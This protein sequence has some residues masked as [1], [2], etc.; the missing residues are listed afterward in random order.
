MLI[1]DRFEGDFAIVETDNGMINVPKS[2]LPENAKEG[3]ALKFVIDMEATQG[4]KQRIDKMMN[5][6]FKD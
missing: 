4:R 1:I 5:K 3:D 6:L 2:E